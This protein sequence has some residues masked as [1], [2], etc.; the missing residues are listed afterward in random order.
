ME[1]LKS[2]FQLKPYVLG[3]LSL[4]CSCLELNKQSRLVRF[5]RQKCS[6]IQFA[7]AS[8]SSASSSSLGPLSLLSSKGP[9][10]MTRCFAADPKTSL[11]FLHHFA[12][13]MASQGHWWWLLL[14]L[15]NFIFPTFLDIW[16]KLN[17]YDKSLPYL[18]TQTAS[19]SVNEH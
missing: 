18:V 19:A 14:T 5:G 12:G 16:V 3:P 15:Q 9:W 8:L 17:S 7:L 1:F 6:L 4:N 13:P 2:L 11:R 10:P